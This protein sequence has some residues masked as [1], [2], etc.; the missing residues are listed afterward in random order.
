MSEPHKG[1]HKFCGL[2]FNVCSTFE[3]YTVKLLKIKSIKMHMTCSNVI[4]AL[5]W[6]WKTYYTMPLRYI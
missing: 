1:F 6:G 3:M 5:L 4:F 2:S